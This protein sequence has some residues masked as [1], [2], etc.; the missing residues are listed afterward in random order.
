[1]IRPSEEE[2]FQVIE[3]DRFREAMVEEDGGDLQ[4]LEWLQEKNLLQEIIPTPPASP[5][6]DRRRPEAKRKR[7]VTAWYLE[8]VERRGMD[9]K[10]N[11]EKPP[12]SY[13]TLIIMAMKA[14]AHRMT[15]SAVYQ[16]IRENF[17]YYQNADPSWQN[18]IRHNLS[19]NKCFT[20]VPRGKGEQG[21]GGFWQL[22]SRHVDSYLEGLQKKKG[23]KDTPPSSSST[24]SR[25]R[26]NRSRKKKDPHTYHLPAPLMYPHVEA[27]T[28]L[29][30]PQESLSE[31]SIPDAWMEGDGMGDVVASWSK[32][33]GGWSPA[34][35]DM[36]TSCFD[37]DDDPFQS[38]NFMDHMDHLIMPDP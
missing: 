3:T 9:Y 24:K 1:A 6:S 29:I 5:G 22:D 27:L 32:L 18:S 20:K 16:W 33:E 12:Y 26:K 15:L 23:R 36:D 35:L 11:P 28:Q 7:S 2:Y 4:S 31:G 37:L 38:L 25:N 21:K 19:L 34:S 17:L 13:A 30:Q 10:A 8:E 14:N